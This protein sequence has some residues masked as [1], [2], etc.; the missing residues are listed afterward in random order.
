MSEVWMKERKMRSTASNFGRVY[1]RQR[2]HE[3]FC[4]ALLTAK[5]FRSPSTQHGITHMYKIGK[6]VKVTDSGFFVSPKLFIFGCSPDGKVVDIGCEEN[7]GLVEIKCPSSKFAV[8]PLEACADPNFCLHIVDGS[9]KLKRTHVYYD[10]VQGQMGI[11]GVTWCDFIVYTSCG[12]SIERIPFELEH[13]KRLREKLH[14][15][16]FSFFLPAVAKWKQGT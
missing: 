9:P 3:K 6:P 1:R 16:Y 7:F 11:T 15:V 8:T 13:W 4:E 10:Q 5:P 12:L 2:N 14:N